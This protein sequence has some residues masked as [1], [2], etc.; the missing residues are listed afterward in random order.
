MFQTIDYLFSGN[1]K[2]QEAY[3]VIQELNLMNDLSEF[4]PIVCGTIPIEIDIE[5]S[6]LDIILNV[7]HF[8][9]FEN[10][11]TKLYKNYEK[12]VLK[13]TNSRKSPVIKAN[14]LYQGFEFELFG[15]AQPVTKQYAYL[16]MIIEYKL[17][18]QFPEMKEKVIHFKQKG[19]KTE[20][21]FCQ[22]LG[23]KGEDAYETLLAYGRK[24]ALI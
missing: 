8:L 2:Q 13:R 3:S 4:N 15:Q 1:S 24:H 18:I 9:S 10:K 14:F 16:H 7:N 19:V 21:A 11:V 17:M 23:L 6:D 22:V 12:F 20:R 5:G